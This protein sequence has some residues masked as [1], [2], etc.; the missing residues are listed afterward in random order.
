VL[1]AVSEGVT[2]ADTLWML[3]TDGPITI[4]TTALTF[5]RKDAG[6]AVGVPTGWVGFYARNTPPTGFLKANG[7]LVSRTTYAALFAVIGT[8]F[9]AG[10]GSTT[11]ELPDLRGEFLRCLDDGR[12]VDSGRGIGTSQIS[13]QILVDDDGGQVTGA[14]D[15]TNNNLPALGYETGN[16]SSVISHHFVSSTYTAPANSIGSSFIRSIRPRNI[17]LLA[18]IKY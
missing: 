17:A 18:C 7:A 11:F 1:C 13:T 12:G 14:I 8:T 3:T 16:P 10:D 4:G 5:A 6:A 2:L 15:W 9:G